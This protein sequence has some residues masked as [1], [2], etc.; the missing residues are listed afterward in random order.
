M[1][2]SLYIAA[3]RFHSTYF[4]TKHAI[5]LFSVPF[6]GHVQKLFHM[7]SQEMHFN[8]LIHIGNASPFYPSLWY[9]SCSLRVLKSDNDKHTGPESWHTEGFYALCPYT[10][11]FIRRQRFCAAGKVI[12]LNINCT[13]VCQ[14]SKGASGESNCY[15]SAFSNHSLAS[16]ES[17]LTQIIS[18]APVQR[19]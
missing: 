6:L 9:F 14:L 17:L 7:A 13:G 10:D 8:P 5:V 15:F 4:N 2:L 1:S 18:V 12:I 11:F 19:A 3:L 16:G